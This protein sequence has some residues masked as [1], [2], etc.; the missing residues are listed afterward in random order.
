MNRSDDIFWQQDLQLEYAQF[1]IAPD[2]NRTP[3]ETRCRKINP[4]LF[5]RSLTTWKSRT[6]KRTLETQWQHN[7]VS[8]PRHKQQI[9]YVAENA[10]AILRRQKAA[11][12]CTS[13]VTSLIHTLADCRCFMLSMKNHWNH[14]SRRL[15][16]DSSW[17]HWRVTSRYKSAQVID[18]LLSRGTALWTHR[19]PSLNLLCHCVQI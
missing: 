9:L 12:L 15:K 18:M 16:L 2:W 11:L 13:Q 17:R 7:T 10:L 1:H 8:F 3:V 4:S 19:P 6:T 5:Y 14:S